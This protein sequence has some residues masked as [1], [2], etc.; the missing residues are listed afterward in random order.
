MSEVQKVF[1]HHFDS[2]STTVEF[3]PGWNNSTGYLN[4]AV[5]APLTETCKSECPETKRRVILIPTQF[6]G[7]V[8]IFE[9]LSPKG[10]Q[11]SDTIVSNVPD[12]LRVILPGSAWTPADIWRF[13]DRN[14]FISL[15]DS[16]VAYYK[17]GQ[18]TE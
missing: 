8:V 9:R 6:G 12:A 1:A 3:Q 15:F 17:A 10:E 16:A 5:H 7:N 13:C 14:V 18:R 4:G 2:V 11:R